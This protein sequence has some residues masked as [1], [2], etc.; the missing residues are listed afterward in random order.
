MAAEFADGARGGL[1]SGVP[2]PAPAPAAVTPLPPDTVSVRWLVPAQIP[3]DAWP[4]LTAC[5]DDGER[6]R[7]AR[8]HF[9]ADREAYIAAHALTRGML[10]A[11]APRAPQAWRFAPTAHGRPEIARAFDDPLLRFNLSHSRGLVAVAVTERRDVGIDVEAVDP[12]RLSLDLAAA[13]FAPA[14]VAYVRGL[15]PAQRPEALFAL[16]TLKEAYIK[17]VGQGLSLPLDSFAI[18]LAPLSIQF[19]DACPDDP[20]I[21]RLERL[22]P[23]RTHALALAVRHPQPAAVMVDAAAMPVAELLAR[24]AQSEGPGRISRR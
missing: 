12:S 19:S 4:V 23:I 16:W 10:S 24:C 22:R 11:H 9:A 18:A 13:T 6:A 15:S 7:S 17:A 20:A 3:P 8:F 2:D 14:E 5:L 21:W 1:E